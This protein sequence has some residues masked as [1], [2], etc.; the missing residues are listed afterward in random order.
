MEDGKEGERE[1]TME[2]GRICWDFECKKINGNKKE[3]NDKNGRQ[4]GRKEA[5]KKGRKR[6][7]NKQREG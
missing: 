2:K 6:G 1:E 3:D 4:V 7:K 5:G